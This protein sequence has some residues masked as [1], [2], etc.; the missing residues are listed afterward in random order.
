M[1]VVLTPM[2]TAEFDAWQGPAIAGYAQSFVD[3]GI[4]SPEEAL[5]R[6]KKDFVELL[7]EGTATPEHQLWTAW[8]G[9]DAVGILWVK[10]SGEPPQRRA[11][12]YDIEVGEAHRRHGYASAMIEALA[13][14]ARAD[15]VSSIGLN[16]FGHNDGAI[17][18]YRKLG[19]ETTSMQMKLAL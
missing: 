18:L 1:A 17:D 6:S 14:L 11:F 13:E 10:T 4:L 5:E 19:F 8:S 7:A 15:D 3:A 12:I 9:D 16:V 2:T